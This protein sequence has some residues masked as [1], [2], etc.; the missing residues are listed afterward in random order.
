MLSSVDLPQPEGPRMQ[1]NS[2][3]ATS[4][5]MSTRAGAWRPS[6]ANALLTRWMWILAGP[7]I[8][9]LSPGAASAAGAARGVGAPRSRTNRA[10]PARS[11]LPA[12]GDQEEV[13]PVVDQKAQA[14]LGP[15]ELRDDDHE[16]RQRHPQPDARQ[17]LGQCRRQ[18]H[19]AEEL[20]RASPQALGGPQ[21]QGIDLPDG[22]DRGQKHRKED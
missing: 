11:P 20:G 7:G 8:M 13:A 12:S 14:V 9:A 6:T 16:K 5:S 19:A 4:S 17:D 15:D 10:G 3:S 1:R 21:Q 18:D 22:V 2:R